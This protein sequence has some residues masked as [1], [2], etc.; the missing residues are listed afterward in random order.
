[1]R[2]HHQL[3]RAATAGAVVA[4]VAG[5]RGEVL[6]PSASQPSATLSSA[7]STT[8]FAYDPQVASTFHLGGQHRITFAAGAVC[9]PA[10]STYG[11]AEWD[12]PCAPL[13]APIAITSRA[14]TDAL[15]RPRVDFSPALRFVPGREVVL[16]L[17]DRDAAGDS[18]AVI[19][20][21]DDAGACVT[22]APTSPAYETRRDAARGIY[23]RAIKHFSGYMITAG[24]TLSSSTE[25]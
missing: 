16:Y 4:L 24:R 22:E 23:Y 9:D 19:Q 7:G 14:Y 13:A 6:A 1:M 8:T 12:Q 17:R 2:V 3:H 11:P 15:G 21:C 5:C 25:L 20:W 18:T 10:V